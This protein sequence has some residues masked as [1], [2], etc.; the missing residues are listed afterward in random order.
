MTR[1]LESRPALAATHGEL[2]LF[3]EKEGRELL[4]RMLQGHHTLRAL[5]ERPVRVE[6][7]DR[8]LRTFLRPS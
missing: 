8:V 3:V 1:Y 2:E 7:S 6:G 4:C 5:A